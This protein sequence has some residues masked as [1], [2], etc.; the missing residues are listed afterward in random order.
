MVSTPGC[1]EGTMDRGKMVTTGFSRRPVARLFSGCGRGPRSRALRTVI[2]AVCVMAASTLVHALHPISPRLDFIGAYPKYPETDYGTGPESE[3][4][5]RGDYLARLGDC[6]ACHT[7]AQPGAP[8]FAGGLPMATPFGTFYTPNITPDK[9]T[10]IGSWREED[11][12]RMMHEGIRPDGSNA[13][14]AFPY[15]FFNR[16]R[17]A[18][19][20]DLWAYLRAIPSV[21]R[22]NQGNTL[23]FPFDVRLAQYGWKLLFFYPHRGFF[24]EDPEQSP[25]WNRG[26]YLVEGLG[27]CSMCH[28]PL[29]LL[30]ATRDKYYL[31][32]ALI[33]GYW[34]PD[35]TRRGLESATRFE[36]ADVFDE[37]KLINRAGDVRGPMADAI[38][39]SL[40]YLTEADR[41]AIAEYL[42][43]VVSRQPRD[44]TQL[45]AGQP[46]LKRGA[47]VYANVCVLCHLNGEAGAPSIR[48]G[49]NWE[50]R[51]TQRTLSVLYRH[52]VEGFNKMP[53]MGAC[54]TC[55]TED[56]HAGVDY[57]I[58]RA[59]DESRRRELASPAPASR[60]VSTSLAVGEQV[61]RQSCS[62]CHDGG[63]LGAPVLGDESQWTPLLRRD[64]EVLIANSLRGINN[65][66][67]KG[68]CSECSNSEI[69]AAVKFMAQRSQSGRDFSLW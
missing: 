6:I 42:K 10:G 66:P 2:V 15:V 50:R 34:A 44:I 14:P 51:V 38:H 45:K 31:T 61:Y 27:H 54:V 13:F 8:P 17:V 35:I 65:M 39:D 58:Y 53:P 11:F 64:F 57:L 63:A 22:K 48:D 47:Q 20:K 9:E 67:P 12:I 19:L 16:V 25:A 36:V 30:G 68:G 55:S 23:P 4:I 32:G 29:N 7:L 40:R 62:T 52:A 24:T 59:L 43:S 3:A 21:A 56:V 60:R 41:L 28:T 49:A 5:R 69:I 46:V 37:G 18:D 1:D 33:E 26:A